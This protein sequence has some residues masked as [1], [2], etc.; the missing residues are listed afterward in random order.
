MTDHTLDYTA[1]VWPQYENL[2]FLCTI[3]HTWNFPT[4]RVILGV[5]FTYRFDYVLFQIINLIFEIISTL[6]YIILISK[7]ISAVLKVYLYVDITPPALYF[8]SGQ[9]MYKGTIYQDGEDVG[10]NTACDGCKCHMG[11]IECLQTI[12]ADLMCAVRD[13]I[14]PPGEC[15]Q[16]CR[17]GV[18]NFQLIDIIHIYLKLKLEGL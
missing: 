16:E 17:P 11:K 3:S 10:P 5:V 9:C 15:C 14:T 1:V 7:N 12:C 4:V 8:I 2:L 13:R 18:E 6:K